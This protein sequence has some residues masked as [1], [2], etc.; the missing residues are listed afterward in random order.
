MALPGV[1]YLRDIKGLSARIPLVGK[2]TSPKQH[3]LYLVHTLWEQYSSAL[4]TIGPDTWKPENQPCS[5]RPF[6]MLQ[7][8]QS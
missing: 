1:R 2:L 5:T 7:T 6:E 4:I 3:L 8:S